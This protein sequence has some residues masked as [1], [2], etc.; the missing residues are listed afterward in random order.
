MASRESLIESIFSDLKKQIYRPLYLLFG[1]EPYFIDVIAEFIEKNVLTDEEKEFNLSIIYGKDI[2]AATLISYARRYPMMANYQVLIVREAQVME[3]L[4]ELL[5]YAGNPVPSTLLVI[6]Y[7]YGK[8]DK[9]KSLYKAFEKNGVV[10]ESAHLYDNQIPDWIGAYV[11]KHHYSITPKAAILLNEFVGNELSNIV[12]ELGKLFINLPPQTVINE[13][14]IERNIG[15]SK[16]FNVF[17]LQKALG[18]KDIYKSNLIINHFGANTRENPI[19]KVIPMLYSFFSKVL[20]YHFLPDKSQKNVASALSVH[21]YFLNDFT[22]AARNYSPAKLTHVVSLLR[23]Y[24]L[25]AKG[26][27]N[28]STTDGELLKEMIYRILH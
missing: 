18:N 9:R 3:D 8:I 5:P 19:V 17:E 15:I 13:G 20:V 23:E 26:V 2:D 24:D 21:P 14:H 28:A 4:D 25:K 27:D 16:D 12:N 11:K 22:R 6:C 1:E 10:F 7:K